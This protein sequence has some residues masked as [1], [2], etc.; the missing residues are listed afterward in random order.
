MSYDTVAT[1]SQ[2]TS[3]LFFI[4]LFIGVLIYVFWPG[5]RQR[6]DEAQRQALNLESETPEQGG[7]S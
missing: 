1:I 4:A 2:V 6:F 5:N 7:R 3:L